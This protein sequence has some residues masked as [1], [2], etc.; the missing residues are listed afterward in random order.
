[1]VLDE[2]FEKTFK[3]WGRSYFLDISKDEELPEIQLDDERN[4]TGTGELIFE[5]KRWHDKVVEDYW[6]PLDPG[7]IHLRLGMCSNLYRD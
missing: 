2:V 5:G 3:K 1:M 6:I 7:T 4:C